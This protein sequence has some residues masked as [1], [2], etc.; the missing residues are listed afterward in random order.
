MTAPDD[1]PALPPRVGLLIVNL[2]TPDAPTPAA[3][4]RYLAQFLSDPRVVEI[5]RLAWWPILHGVILRTR[6]AKSAAKY[7]QVWTKEGSPLAVHTEHQAKRLQGT[8]GQH[9]G[10]V[11]VR[12]AMRY[13][14]PAIAQ[15]LDA[16]RADGAER[17]LVFPLYPQYCAA[18]TASVAD[19]VA[20]WTQRT[21]S[22]PEL[23]L[24]TRYHDDPAYVA[25][26]ADQV[27]A[28]WQR[29]GRL[30]R[31][32]RLVMSFHGMPERTRR[33]G[34]PYYDECQATARLVALALGLRD[35]EWV[36]TFQS[37]FG[38]ARWL[39]PYTA[40]TL[41][42]LARSGVERVAVLCPGFASDCL[43]TLEEIA[44]EGR[45]AFLGAGGKSFHYLPCL[46]ATEPGI[47]VLSG[48]VQRHLVGWELPPPSR[49]TIAD[50]EA[51]ARERGTA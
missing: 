6:P 25:A 8:L 36:T 43:E 13:G 1:S 4:R 26:L 35:D 49:D 17:I 34:D 23:R 2:G 29:E 30:D 50:R 9:V 15:E 32:E 48:V 5:P 37:R 21:R 18:T 3:T 46:N 33:L 16:L 41:Q 28:H 39:E 51:R 45:D 42:A 31:G 40:P 24:V 27:R 44:M 11:L 7:A 10:P 19:D 14:R 38:R 47:R 22:L 20:A 12:W